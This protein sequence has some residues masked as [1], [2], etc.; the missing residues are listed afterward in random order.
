MQRHI[1]HR[2]ETLER[3]SARYGIPVCMLLR[4]N[5]LGAPLRPGMELKIPPRD[6]CMRRLKTTV[7]HTVVPGDTVFSLAQQYKTIMRLILKE[8]NLRHPRELSPGQTIT[9]PLAPGGVYTV[10]QTDTLE[11]IAGKLGISAQLLR[12]ANYLKNSS[13]YPGMQ[14]LLP[15]QT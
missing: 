11:S 15:E 3:I 5:D 4:A 6:F 9:I 13:V 1:L 2:G 14:L 7:L 12:Q 10:R 8:N